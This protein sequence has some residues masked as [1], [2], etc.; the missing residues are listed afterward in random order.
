MD[1]NILCID[2]HVDFA[3]HGKAFVRSAEPRRHS[4]W[5]RFSIESAESEGPSPKKSYD[6]MASALSLSSFESPQRN[7][8]RL[9]PL[10]V[11]FGFFEVVVWASTCWVTLAWA[12]ASS[13]A[14]AMASASALGVLGF[15]S[16][17]IPA[18]FSASVA[19]RLSS[20][21]CTARLAALACAWRLRFS[22]P[23]GLPPPWLWP[24]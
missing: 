10:R 6:S 20:A 1:F 21:G 17:W 16:S 19:L 15:A 5:W 18:A 9:G 24:P 12:L 11:F 23:G 7:L 13:V 3:F 2:K 14:L 8:Q 22:V 4:F